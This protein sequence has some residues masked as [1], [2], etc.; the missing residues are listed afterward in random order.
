MMSQFLFDIVKQNKG[1]TFKSQFAP[2]GERF[3]FQEK[4]YIISF[5][6]DVFGVM[7]SF[8]SLSEV[9][10]F[11][12]DLDVN[13]QYKDKKTLHKFFGKINADRLR[14]I[15]DLTLISKRKREDEEGIDLKSFRAEM[16]GNSLH[17]ILAEKESEKNN[18]SGEIKIKGDYWLINPVYP[19]G[20][21]LKALKMRKR[22]TAVYNPWKKRFEK[23]EY[24]LT[25]N[26]EVING[27]KAVEVKARAYGVEYS[28]FLSEA[29]ELLKIST[30]VGLNIVQIPSDTKV[31]IENYLDIEKTF[32]ILVKNMKKEHKKK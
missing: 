10:S 5:N 16:K 3:L 20:R 13:Y 9:I 19:F 29:G 1:V 12:M 26:N 6:G 14:N 11:E 21:N 24:D 27:L 18:F 8:F 30:P 15:K 2:T 7:N 28:L 32:K 31:D 22:M 4:K 25:K 23:I 17:Y